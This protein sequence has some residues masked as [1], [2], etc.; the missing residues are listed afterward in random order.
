VFKF[1]GGP[2][3]WASRKQKSVT[4]STAEAE[5]MAL[6]PATKHAIWL[7]KFLNE[8]G[9]PQFI[10]TDSRTVVINE[11]N[12]AAIKMVNNNQITERSKHI[13]IGCHFLRGRFENQDINLRYCHTDKMAADG[14]IKGLAKAKFGTFL[15]LLGL[16]VIKEES[17]YNAVASR[18]SG[19]SPLGLT[20]RHPPF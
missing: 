13:D 3:S 19:I 6:V 16:K 1:A 5:L 8:I 18:A 11:D 20:S 10:G 17:A 7:S 4:T 12:Q 2:I 14:C 9:R 15:N